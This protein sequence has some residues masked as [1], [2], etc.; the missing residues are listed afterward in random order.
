MNNRYDKKRKL[1]TVLIAL[2]G[3]L[4]VLVAVFIYVI[5]S[6]K[7]DKQTGKQG[8]YDVNNE[9]QSETVSEVMSESD[10]TAISTTVVATLTP[11]TEPP[12]IS[13]VKDKTFNVGDSVMYM[14]GVSAV[15][16]VDG[17]VDVE[18]D[19]SAVNIR[20]AGSYKV[21]YTA[22]DKA[23]NIATKEAIYT[24]KVVVSDNADYRELSNQLLKIIYDGK[25]SSLSQGQKLR[26][27]YDYI[28]SK[29]IYGNR[30]LA[31]S[32]WQQEAALGLKEIITKGSTTGDCFTS[33]S[34]CMAVLETMGAQ[35]K[36]M[37]NLGPEVCGSNHVWVL[38]NVGTGWYHFDTTRYYKAGQRFMFTDAQLEE[39]M[40]TTG[41]YRFKRDMSVYPASATEPF[42]Y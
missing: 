21:I 7:G 12:V 27:I 24:F 33:A 19:K 1:A 18:V 4:V 11:D 16:D 13:G 32:T 10:T 8:D 15:D 42:T 2:L 3:L 5:C 31:G 28:Y 9:T 20:K 17:E 37:Q 36:W 41:Y 6:N 23:G 26:L 34:L 35:V 38:C 40:S 22:K 30:K 39:W 29:T 25:E 14:S